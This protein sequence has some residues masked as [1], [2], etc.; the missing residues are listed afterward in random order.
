[1]FLVEDDCKSPP[2]LSDHLLAYPFDVFLDEST[3]HGSRFRFTC[4]DRCT[5]LGSEFSTCVKGEWVTEEKQICG[6]DIS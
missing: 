5:L 2:E 3:L 6:R 4:E 1:M